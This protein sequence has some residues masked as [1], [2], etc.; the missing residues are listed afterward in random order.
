MKHIILIFITVCT[1]FTFSNKLVATNIH[2]VYVN[3][4]KAK[5]LLMSNDSFTDR[6]NNF[7]IAV[8]THS[9]HMTKEQLLKI[10]GKSCL[11]WSENDKNKLDSIAKYIERRIETLGMKTDIPK[12]IIMIKT[13]ME[14]EGNAGAYTRNNWIAIGQSVMD[15]DIS[16]LTY[17]VGHEL[18]HILTR[19]SLDFKRRVYS[20]IGF[21]IMDHEIQF[22]KDIKEKIISNPDVDR[23]DS[24]SSFNINGTTQNCSMILYTKKTY[25]GGSLFDYCNVGLVPLDNNLI[26]IRH[27]GKT[28]IYSLDE[29]KDFYDKVGNNTDYVFNPEEILADNFSFLIMGDNNVPDKDLLFRIINALK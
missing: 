25:N 3:K 23:Y 24:Y 5:E 10:A 27:D 11:D 29:A 2:F 6:W 28:L 14:E 22:E 21:K 18:F 17:I 9:N 16:K 20:T 15:A 1:L 13:T 12:E 19:H 4:D 8:R 7:D 26:P